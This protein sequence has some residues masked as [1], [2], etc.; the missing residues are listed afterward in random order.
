MATRQT[1][2]SAKGTSSSDIAKEF[3]E[4]SERLQSIRKKAADSLPDL[5]KQLQSEL[6]EYNRL[7]EISDTGTEILELRTSEDRGNPEKVTEARQEPSE[8]HDGNTGADGDTKP[9]N[10]G[11][12]GAEGHVAH[13]PSRKRGNVSDEK[14]L[15]PNDVQLSDPDGVVVPDYR[16]EET[17]DGDGHDADADADDDGGLGFLGDDDA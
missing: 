16:T 4:A 3:E 1:N 12:N 2:A 7:A 11:G 10:G 5:K 15:D 9:A 14:P 8:T 13:T 17:D 6:E